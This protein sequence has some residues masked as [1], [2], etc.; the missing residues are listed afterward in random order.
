MTDRFDPPDWPYLRL[1]AELPPGRRLAAL[2]DSRELATGLMRGRLRRQYPEL[3][4]EAIN[5]KLFEEIER[6]KQ[7]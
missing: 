6:T 2:L 1:R 7:R 4:D 5:L 3:S